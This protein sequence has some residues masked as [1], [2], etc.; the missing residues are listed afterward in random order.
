MGMLL[1]SL[2]GIQLGALTTRV[3]KGIYIRGFYATAILAGF[4]NRLLA[5]PAKLQEM[6]VLDI[7]P[8]LAKTIA[9]WGNYAFFI[10][11]TIF[12]LWVISKFITN[13]PTLRRD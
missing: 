10:V 7:S 1:G 6:E 12:A 5:L 3:V 2:L 4:I 11:V 9:T 13:I 8:E